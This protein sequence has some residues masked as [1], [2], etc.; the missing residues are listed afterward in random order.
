MSRRKLMLAAGGV[1]LALALAVAGPATFFFV[2]DGFPAMTN[3]IAELDE[4]ELKTIELGEDDIPAMLSIV[5][6]SFDDP[7]PPLSVTVRTPDGAE[8][9][10][11]QADGWHSILGRRYRRVINILPTQPGPIELRV[12][13][14]EG[15][16]AEDFAL[17]RHP[18]STME[19]FEARAM[20]YWIAAGV[21]ALIALGLVVAAVISKAAE[22]T[23]LDAAL[24]DRG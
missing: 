15:G 16:G 5:V 2:R 18:A 22:R 23:D 14:Q 13:T 11:G 10:T 21:L 20:P 8:V 24:S 9:P 4:G 6:E 17:F 7:V 12:D 19:R 1:L 3:P